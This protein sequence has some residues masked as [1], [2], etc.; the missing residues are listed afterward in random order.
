MAV[1]RRFGSRAFRPGWIDLI[2]QKSRR[3]WRLARFHPR[4]LFQVERI[5]L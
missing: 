3:G 1:P 2:G 5:V 4:N